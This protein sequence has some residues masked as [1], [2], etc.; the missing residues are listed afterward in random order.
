MINPA[1]KQTLTGVIS[2][3]EPGRESAEVISK[4]AINLFLISRTAAQL[5]GKCRAGSRNWVTLE[6]LRWPGPL[7]PE[8]RP[9]RELLL[10]TASMAEEE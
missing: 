2:H 5:L 3:R 10:G 8:A 6:D 4:A 9:P 7:P 1:P